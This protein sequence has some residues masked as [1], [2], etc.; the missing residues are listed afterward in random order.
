MIQTNTTRRFFEGTAVGEAAYLYL[1]PVYL[2]AVIAVFSILSYRTLLLKVA[3]LLCLFL[4]SF[5]FHVDVDV[6]VSMSTLMLMLMLMLV[7]HLS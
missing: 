5:F 4:F 7:N 2:I 3:I 1:A 6:D